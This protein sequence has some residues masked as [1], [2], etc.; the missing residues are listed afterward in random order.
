MNYLCQEANSHHPLQ[1]SEELNG[2]KIAVNN[3]TMA[4]LFK[5]TL[6]LSALQLT[7]LGTVAFITIAI[8]VRQK[9]TVRHPDN[10]PR[11]REN[12]RTRFSLRTRLAW[13]TDCKSLFPEAYETVYPFFSWISLSN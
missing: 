1:E 2:K 5:L 10:L 13:Y 3:N 11:I 8:L 12:G 7:A 6:G 4:N 9:F